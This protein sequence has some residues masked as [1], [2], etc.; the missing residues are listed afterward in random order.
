MNLKCKSHRGFSSLNRT[1]TLCIV[2]ID[3]EGY[4]SR[5]FMKMISDKKVETIIQLIL[6]NVLIGTTVFTDEHFK[7]SFLF[8]LGYIH[9][10]SMS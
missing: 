6:K 4:I 10:K 5:A 7:Y 2:E 3:I 8:I 1:D 9:K